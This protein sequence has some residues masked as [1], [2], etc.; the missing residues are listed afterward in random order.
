VFFQLLIQPE[1]T[2]TL[3]EVPTTTR[4][5]NMLRL[6][7][8]DNEQKDLK[9]QARRAVGRV[10]ERIHFVLLSAQG[11]SPPEIGAPLTSSTS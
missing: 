2:V 11:H 3:V 6:E 10:S 4:E 7:L 1:Q 9:L 8:N 5:T